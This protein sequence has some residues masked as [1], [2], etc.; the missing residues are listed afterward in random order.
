MYRFRERT[1]AP[2]PNNSVDIENYFSSHNIY[3][4][5]G[6][7]MP[8]CTAYALGRANEL[9]RLNDKGY[10]SVDGFAGNGGTWGENGFIGQ[11][12]ERGSIPMVGAIAVFKQE[13]RDGHVA[14]VEEVL[15]NNLVKLSNSGWSSTD[16]N[17]SNAL[18]WWIRNDTDVNNWG[19]YIFQYYLYPPYID[20][21][22]EPEPPTPPKPT[23][24]ENWIRLALCGAMQNNL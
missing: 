18:W 24:A 11:S 6:Y 13:G 3:Y 14:I 21:A 15:D 20:D 19:S 17:P 16:R 2:D 8:N 12:W 9:S 7:G 5:S 22:P 23:D 1:V 4:S 10:I